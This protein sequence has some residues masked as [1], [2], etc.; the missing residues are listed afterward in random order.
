MTQHHPWFDGV[1]RR[2]LLRTGGVTVGTLGLIPPVA[3]S[4]EGVISQTADVFGQGPEG[5]VL[6]EDGATLRRTR[7]GLSMTL[8]MPTPEPGSY[9]YPSGPP[10]GAWT[11]EE[12]P[13]EV[14]T[15]WCFVFDPDQPAFD[16]PDAEWTGVFGVVGHVVGGSTLTLS[17]GVSTNTEPFAGENLENPGEAE[18]HLAVAPHGALDPELLPEALNTPTGPGPDIWWLALFD[19]PN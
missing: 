7:N 11:D 15:L 14:F 1:S 5:P 19:P 16:P 18:V 12:G 9:T 13:P 2:Q 10:G 17:G 4:N 3:A 6:A 8:S